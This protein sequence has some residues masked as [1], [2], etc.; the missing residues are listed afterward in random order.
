MPSLD[1]IR[2][3]GSIK[4]ISFDIIAFTRNMTAED[5]VE[6]NTIKMRILK[7]R[8]TGLTGDAGAVF[9]SQKTGRLRALDHFEAVAA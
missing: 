7:S 5:E 4:Q 9:Y 1:D 3:S 8:Y 6:K 2:G